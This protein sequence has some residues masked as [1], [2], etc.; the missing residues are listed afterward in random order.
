MYVNATDLSPSRCHVQEEMLQ[1]CR[2]D[3]C[4]REYLMSYFGFPRPELDP[5]LCC[6]NN[7]LLRLYSQN[8]YTY[9]SAVK[10]TYS[11]CH[12]DACVQISIGNTKWLLRYKGASQT[13]FSGEKACFHRERRLGE[14]PL[15]PSSRP[16][17][18]RNLCM[19]NCCEDCKNM[20]TF[21]II[22]WFLFSRRRPNSPLS[23]T[24]CCLNLKWQ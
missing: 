9:N 23:N 24:T 8:Y 10:I 1:Y 6:D 2:L 13:C 5:H 11:S 19:L 22:S 15:G 3:S 18:G 4:R 7:I 16:R 12:E 17:I 21:C 14:T 20:F